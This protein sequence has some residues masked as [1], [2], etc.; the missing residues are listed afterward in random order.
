MKRW[1]KWLSKDQASW[2]PSFSIDAKL[3]Q[4]TAL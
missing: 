4:S 1:E 3:R 2:I